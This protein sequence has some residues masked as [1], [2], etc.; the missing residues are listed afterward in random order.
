MELSA[1]KLKKIAEGANSRIFLYGESDS[2]VV[3][4][5]VDAD[6]NKETNHLKN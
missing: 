6:A 5:L 1:N 4:K 2:A 3:L